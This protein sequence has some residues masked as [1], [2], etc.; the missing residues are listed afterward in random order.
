MSLPSHGVSTADLA[1]ACRAW[2][3]RTPAPLFE[4]RYAAKLCGPVLG[5]ALRVRPFERLLAKTVS[6]TILPVATSIA[7]RARFAEEAI[8]AAVRDGAEQYVILGPG[9]DSFAFR[10][11]DLMARIQVFEVDHPITQRCKLRRLR[12]AGLSIG[13]NHHFVA[14]DLERVSPVEAL[15]G[16]PFSRTR[17]SCISLLGVAY[18]IEDKTLRATLQSLSSALPAGTRLSLDWLLDAA[19][20]DPAHADMRRHLLSFVARRGEPMRAQYS[21]AEMREFAAECGFRTLAAVP[22]SALA[23]R[24]GARQGEAPRTIPGLFGI[25][26]LEAEQSPASPCAESPG[27]ATGEGSTDRRLDL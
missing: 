4:D 3:L 11:P 9:M 22:V 19:S 10:R 16:S 1:A 25:A 26:V 20:C 14:A 24:Y 2:H 18:Y 5:L 7:A 6:S 15:Q 23:K 27:L 17:L 21:L 8:E 12:R 13:S